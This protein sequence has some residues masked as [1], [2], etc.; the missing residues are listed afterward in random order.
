MPRKKRCWEPG[1][2]YHITHR[3][4]D[5]KFLFRFTKYREYYLRHLFISVQR[6][7]MDVLDY[8]VT[9][10]HIH[11]LLTAKEGPEISNALR[12]LH[13]R[14]GQWYNT[15]CNKSGAFWG[16]RYHTTQIQS[17]DHLSRCLIYID[18]NMVR[19][20]KV[21]HPRQ[22]KQSAWAELTGG[23]QRCRIINKQRLLQ[24]LWMDSDEQFR[25][26]HQQ[27]IEALKNFLIHCR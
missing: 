11:L 20:G 8:M 22:W 4:H 5:R 15:Q 3:C 12:Y 14:M 6:Y 27:A 19:C 1:A 26:W 2:C 23:R 18:L 21:D 13:G 25:Q 10:N 24:C 16:D 17:G 9:S 7:G